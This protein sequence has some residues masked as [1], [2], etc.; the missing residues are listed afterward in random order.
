MNRI[1]VGIVAL[2][3]ALS[4]TT[5][6]QDVG[7][8]NAWPELTPADQEQVQKFGEDVKTF[9]GQAKS[10][11]LFVRNATQF[12]E[13]NGFRKWDSTAAAESLKPGSRWYA[14]NRD[15]TIVLFVVGAEPIE[16]GLRIVNTH[17]DSPRIEF[18]TRPF[19]ESQQAVLIDTQVHGGIKNYQWANVPLA[20]TG[21]VD[22]ADG[23]T[24]WIDVGNDPGD[25]VLLISDLAPHV[26]RD[27]R[28]R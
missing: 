14:V 6:G 1:T 12:A 18:K 27:F 28:G 2:W 7:F 17:I 10:E 11:M 19:R 21:R 23:T 8:A 16:N 13:S 15:R 3:L 20:I 25:P 5:R 9:L 26:D 24:A 4:A 22:K